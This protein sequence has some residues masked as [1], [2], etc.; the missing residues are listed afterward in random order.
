[1]KD[2]ST[3][4]ADWLLEHKI[5]PRLW[6]HDENIFGK[7]SVGF[8]AWLNEPRR[9]S[10]DFAKLSAIKAKIYKKNFSAI[11]LLGMGGSSLSS[12][13]FYDFFLPPKRFFIVDT[14]HPNNLI[15]LLEKI[16]LK[17][18]LFIVATKSGNTLEVDL[19]YKYFLQLLINNNI[20]DPYA[21][22]LAITDPVS[23]LEQEAQE[24]GFLAAAYGQPKIGGRFSALSVFGLLPAL[25]MDIDANA[26]ATEAEKMAKSCSSEKAPLDNPGLSL[27]LFLASRALAQQENLYL[28]LSPTLASFGPWLEQIIAESLGKDNLG[29]VPILVHEKSRPF[30][31]MHIFIEWQNECGAR[32]AKDADFHFRVSN[33]YQIAQEIF[34][35]QF[36]VSIAATLL[37]VDPFNQPDVEESKRKTRALLQ[38]AL[39]DSQFSHAPLVHETKAMQIYSSEPVAEFFKHKAKYIAILSYLDETPETWQRLKAF[40]HD[41][42][43]KTLC[44]VLI[45][46]GPRYLHST[47]QLFK[48]G[49]KD[50]QFIFLTGPYQNDLEVEKLSLSHV[51]L[52]QALGDFAAMKER[53]LKILHMHCFEL[54]NALSAFIKL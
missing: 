42:E 4:L 39:A 28:H 15:R 51:H 35:W 1:L 3:E 48:G 36:A 13:L 52:S 22:F 30:P 34:R 44:P 25:L 9:I 43:T 19:L 27:G 38:K 24:K 20:E 6:A 26:L 14:I 18:T 12:R 7:K 45:Q 49:P 50:A 46:K 31:G 21:Q 54:A 40:A 5:V 11:V 17:E 8:F 23:P 16:K 10:E 53:A 29:I 41:I 47:G 37:R 2:E 33:K 32:I